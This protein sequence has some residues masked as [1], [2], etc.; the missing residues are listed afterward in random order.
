MIQTDD[1]VIAG[2]S[3]VRNSLPQFIEKLKT[4]SKLILTNRG[5]PVAMVF[6]YEFGQIIE[7]IAEEI[8]NEH[9]LSIALE[10][11]TPDAKWISSE[12]MEK[13]L[14]SR[15]KKKNK[16]ALKRILEQRS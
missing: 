11:D 7:K 6:S 5:Q 2:L 4:S 10:R 12:E 8:E 15:L 9:L 13:R 16:K 14:L 3:E 1:T